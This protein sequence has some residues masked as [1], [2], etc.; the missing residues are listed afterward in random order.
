MRIHEFMTVQIRPI[1]QEQIQV[2]ESKMTLNLDAICA[3]APAT[4]P[5]QSGLCDNGGAPVATPAATIF[6]PGGQILV[7]STYQEVAAL[8]QGIK[9]I[10]DEDE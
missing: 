2:V 8:V 9:L 6:F 10:D 3:F 7:Q 5:S 4:I 1:S